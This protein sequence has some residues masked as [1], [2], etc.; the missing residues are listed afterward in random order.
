MK[1]W[2]VH[3]RLWIA[4]PPGK[5]WW[6]RADAGIVQK[7]ATTSRSR[8]IR[9][10]IRCSGGVSMVSISS[11]MDRPAFCRHG[12]LFPGWNLPLAQRTSGLGIARTTRL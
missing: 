10:S 1:L 12:I 7:R 9:H 3:S 4:K 2:V 11:R 6:W 5:A 8:K